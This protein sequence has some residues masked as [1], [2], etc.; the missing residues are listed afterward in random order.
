MMAYQMTSPRNQIDSRRSSQEKLSPK[1]KLK[2][3][4]VDEKA[5]QRNS[6]ERKKIKAQLQNLYSEL[7]RKKEDFDE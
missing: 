5:N 2:A 4:I 1:K 3:K 7:R 6:I